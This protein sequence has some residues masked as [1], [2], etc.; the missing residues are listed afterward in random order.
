YGLTP[1]QAFEIILAEARKSGVRNDDGSFVLEAG[2][3]GIL[4]KHGHG[5]NLAAHRIGYLEGQGRLV[6]INIG[7]W[8]VRPQTLTGESE[9]TRDKNTETKE[10]VSP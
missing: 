8:E 3:R 10:Q 5:S 4:Q 9:G 2:V 6:H 1:D 7:R